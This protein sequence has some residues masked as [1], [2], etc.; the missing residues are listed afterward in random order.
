LILELKD[1][2]NGLLVASSKLSIQISKNG[3]TDN[4]GVLSDKI[5]RFFFATK[6]QRL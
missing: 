1:A 3:C 4:V 5:A 6:A 2:T